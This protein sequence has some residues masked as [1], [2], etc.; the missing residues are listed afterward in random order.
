M[1]YSGR[2]DISV[3]LNRFSTSWKQENIEWTD[4]VERVR[5]THRTPE[6]LKEF[7]SSKKPRQD[8]IKDI[9]GFVGGLIRGGHR[10]AGAVVYRQLL[11]LDID[12]APPGFWDIFRLMYSEAACIY[13]THKHQPESPRLRLLMPLDREVMADEYQAIG[14]RIAGNLG[15]E[16]F[17]S[18]T[19]QPERLMYWPSTAVDGEYEFFFQD[20]PWI[21]ADDVLGSYY[22]W[23]DI[24]QWPVSEKFKDIILKGNARLGNPLEKPGMIGAFCNCYTVTAGIEKFLRD[25][26]EETGKDDRYTYLG[27]ST[28]GGLVIYDDLFAFSHHGTDPASG[29]GYNIFD[30]VRV[31][32]FAGMDDEVAAKT[33]INKWPSSLAMA[34]FVAL[35]PEVRKY[36]SL[37]KFEGAKAAFSEVSVGISGNLLEAEE[38]DTEW[39]K[40]LSRDRKGNI[41]NTIDNIL[42]IME[43]DPNLKGALVFNAF[44]MRQTVV[45]GLPWRPGIEDGFW[46]DTDDSGIRWYLEIAYGITS[47]G[48]IEDAVE[49]IYERNQIHPVRAY[50]DGLVWD[51]EK[52]IE[53]VFRDFLG[54]DDSDYVRAVSRKMF[55][56]AVGRVYRP[57]I[58][59]DTAIIL[60][61][62]QG[63]GKS[64][65]IEKLGHGWYSDSFGSLE[66][67]RATEQIQGKW[68]IE[69]GEL[70]GMKKAEVNEIKHFMSKKEDRFR[71]A[72][73]HRV[74]DFKRQCIFIGTT[75]EMEFLQDMTGN[76]RYW[77]ILL[78]LYAPFYSVFTDL[79]GMV[80]QLWAE[81]VAC[82]KAGE[83]LYLDERLEQ[84]ARDIQTEHTE[85]Y[86]A[87]PAIMDY[88]ERLYPEDWDTLSIYDRRNYVNRA[89][90]LD[91]EKKPEILKKN[92]V[93]I[94]EIWVEVMGGQIKDLNRFQARE[95]GSF[96]R[97]LKDWK[98]YGK[99][100]MRFSGY[101]IQK[102]F[103]RKNWNFNRYST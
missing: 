4:F 84:V 50:L 55:C 90:D 8:E 92:T 42:I 33:P 91:A 40:G 52:R 75:N 26:Y 17:D 14:R 12:F 63:L 67:N 95:I 79:E 10:T 24:S 11:T 13:S 3:G 60:I 41:Q 9:G 18:T 56:G 39:L 80:D 19:F 20:G 88:L 48:K 38:M 71:P 76:R 7:L 57:G 34:D 89:E 25:V 78:F 101:G 77:P 36:L 68:L 29:R 81:A 85:Q 23:K 16:Y 65:L 86:P 51:G 54:A 49:I 21:S 30:L 46:T 61:G 94:Q 37:K 93:C 96:L 53:T 66:N 31:H 82:F 59:F 28:S 44:S 98:P 43:N 69:I 58:K 1:Q 62:P 15:I 74:M 35:D 97:S 102:A 64:T 6:K 22:D 45:R 5:Y 72:F 99:Q 2:F 83:K 70:S 32:K 27:G 73:A 103:I 87:G 47:G 100:C